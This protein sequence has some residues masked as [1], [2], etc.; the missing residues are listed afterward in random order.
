[1]PPQRRILQEINQNVRR[2]P[3]LT[4]SQREKIIGRLA[5]GAAV[6]EVA[7]LYGRTPRCI[8]DLRKKYNQTGNTQDKPR[9]GRPPILSLRL[10]KLIYRKARAQPKIEYKKLIEE[11]VVVEPD[12]TTSKPPS[13]STLYRVLKRRGLTNFRCKKRP[14]L[15][16][17]HARKR[18]TFCST[19]RN[20]P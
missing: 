14:K 10:K 18:R 12:G 20:F 8:R 16:F 3:N 17:V 4:I 6:K 7:A 13:H 19:Y 9:S 2:G 11:A 5:E 1:M 15:T